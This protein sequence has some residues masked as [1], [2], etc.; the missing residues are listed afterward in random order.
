MH[1]LCYKKS[2][3]YY[4]RNE[5]KRYKYRVY[6]NPRSKKEG[7]STKRTKRAKS[8]EKKRPFLLS[9]FAFKLLPCSPH[10]PLF[11]T[12][13]NRTR[14][15]QYRCYSQCP[16]IKG[17]LYKTTVKTVEIRQKKRQNRGVKS[18]KLS[19]VLPLSSVKV[20]RFNNYNFLSTIAETPIK[21]GFPD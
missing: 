10:T 14:L 15:L 13:H 4:L 16:C 17:M 12:S 9:N 3:K 20:S 6:Q 5:K 21:Q 19:E 7:I 2:E 1:Y 8:L 11:S 18:P